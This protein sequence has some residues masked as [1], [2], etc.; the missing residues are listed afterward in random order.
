MNSFD[1]QSF[2]NA[3]GSQN[4]RRELLMLALA[5]AFVLFNAVSLSLVEAGSIVLQHL[6]PFFVWL[7]VFAA[8]FVLLHRY[9]PGHDVFFLPVI[10]LLSGWGLV[11]LDRLVPAFLP[12]QVIWLVVAATALLL[13]ALL[14]TSLWFLRRYRYVWLLSGLIL[15]GTTLVGTNI[16]VV[17]LT[18]LGTIL[19][20]RFF[21]EYG[22][23]YAFLIFL[24]L[25]L[26]FGEIVPKSVY[27]Q[28]ADY[29]SHR[30]IYP[31]QFFS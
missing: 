23:L 31:L 29:L 7:L 28:K 16:S 3:V 26:I 1:D 12:R 18:T 5:G 8:L 13:A 25:F 9:R 19:M 15:L 17:M 24:P 11:V 27:Q 4:A 2:L 14:P 21:G 10:S 22:D 30:I 20:I 6:Y